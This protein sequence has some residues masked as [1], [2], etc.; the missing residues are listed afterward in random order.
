MNGIII[1]DKPKTWTSHDVINKI[2]RIL[3]A[4]KIGHAGTLDPDATGVL[5]VL[6]NEATK[7]SDYLIADEKEYEFEIV[8][9]ESTETE[10][11]SGNI[12]DEKKVDQ[13]ENVDEVLNSLIGQLEQVP[14]MYSSVHVEGRK[15]YEY[16][17]EGLTI[18]RKAREV[19]IYE[20]KRTSEIE[21]KNDKAYFSVLTR[22]SK[23]TYIR[24]L[25]VEIGNRLNFPAHLGNLRRISS[26][27]LKIDKACTIADIEAGNF[28]LISM[29]EAMSGRII[30]EVSENEYKQVMNGKPLLLSSQADE[31]VLSFNEQMI[32]I[33]ERDGLIFRAKRVW[34]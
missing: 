10:D 3:K 31:V 9:G 18:E 22:V 13:L 5:V 14:P 25:A 12:I 28:K 15:L 20:I 11:A 30:I 16:A 19:N 27:K 32:A 2:K 29:L 21:Y 6:L 34:K 1:V 8:I 33:Y 4:K 17:R 26:G 7:L 24:T 23:G